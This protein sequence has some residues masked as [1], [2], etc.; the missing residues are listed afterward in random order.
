MRDKKIKN[1]CITIISIY[2]IVS[3]F[4]KSNFQIHY[5]IYS[6]YDSQTYFWVSN[7]T[8]SVQ[9]VSFS[10]ILYLVQPSFPLLIFLLCI[11][12]LFYFYSY[13]VDQRRNIY[14]ICTQRFHGSTYKNNSSLM[15]Q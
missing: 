6:P 3:I 2:L 8:S 5:P 13:V 15:Y 4:Y 11:L 14:D 7:A 1:I 12:S 10:T 9:T